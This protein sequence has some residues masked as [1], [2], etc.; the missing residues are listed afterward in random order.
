[1]K[2]F[3]LSID[4]SDWNEIRSLMRDKKGFNLKI[5]SE[6]FEIRYDR[7]TM[8]YYAWVSACNFL[9]IDDVLPKRLLAGVA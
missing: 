3:E 9:E 8:R 5:K 6:T 4:E 1:M 7:A 2:E